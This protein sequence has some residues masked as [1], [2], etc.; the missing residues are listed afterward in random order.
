MTE[1]TATQASATK[2][3]T[4][5]AYHVDKDASGKNFWKRIG[6]AWAHKDGNG[7]NL[8]LEFLPADK[9]ITIR[10]ASKKAA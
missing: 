1:N 5:I 2:H 7:F 3:P 9:N 10:S 8:Q 6:A 4:H